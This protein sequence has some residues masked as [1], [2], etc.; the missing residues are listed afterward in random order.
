MLPKLNYVRYA[1]DTPTLNIIIFMFTLDILP[2]CYANDKGGSY[3]VKGC[4]DT[5][6][7]QGFPTAT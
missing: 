7:I 5:A 2:I 3:K 6:Q 1:P 4:S